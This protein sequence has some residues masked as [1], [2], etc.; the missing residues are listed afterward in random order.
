MSSAGSPAAFAPSLHNDD[1][2]PY[3][4]PLS[5]RMRIGLMALVIFFHVGGAWALMSIEP[6]KLEVGDVASMEVR[7]VPSEQTAAAQPEQQP[8]LPTPPDDTPPPEV[9]MVETMIQPPMADLPPPEFP[10]NTPPP[11]PKPPA[12]KPKPAQVAPPTD[13]PPAPSA[14][15]AAASSAPKTV[16][17]S[18]VAYLTPPSPIYPARSRRAG[19]KGTVTV[20]VLIDATGRPTNVAVQGSSGHAALDESAVSA[21]RAARFR[22]YAEGGV[23]QPVWVLVPINFVLQ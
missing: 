5:R 20:K 13:A 6:N 2:P 10:V 15:P 16:S 1:E 12:P 8:D 3:R 23:A 9:P 14:A 7:L 19:E 17:A 22:P 4:E 18:Q 21:V 11:K